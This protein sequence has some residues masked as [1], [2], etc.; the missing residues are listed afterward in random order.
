MESHG[1]FL[2]VEMSRDEYRELEKYLSRSRM[3]AKEFIMTKVRE[4]RDIDR[5]T[6]VNSIRLGEVFRSVR[7][8][9]DLVDSLKSTT[10][11]IN[12]E[13]DIFYIEELIENGHELQYSRRSSEETTNKISNY[14]KK[15]CEVFECYNV[16]VC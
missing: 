9:Q 13:F 5:I 11:N 16:E 12:P 1:E 14:L 3:S 15:V 10:K 4:A 6:E 2:V 7:K 8:L